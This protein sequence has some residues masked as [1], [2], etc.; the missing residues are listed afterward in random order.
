MYDVVVQGL[1]LGCAYIWIYKYMIYYVD[2]SS[3]DWST[4]YANTLV[5]MLSN[6]NLAITSTGYCFHDNN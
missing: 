6:K 1:Y 5:Q 3:M 2:P 4:V